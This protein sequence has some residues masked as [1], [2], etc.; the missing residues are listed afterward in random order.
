VNNA[1][2][3]MWKEAVSAY[4]NVLYHN[5]PR[6]TEENHEKLWIFCR[7]VNFLC[8]QRNRTDVHAHQESIQL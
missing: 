4:L 2:E 1:K 3:R 6:T 7:R 8:S 5:Y